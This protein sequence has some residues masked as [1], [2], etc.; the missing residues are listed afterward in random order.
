M[1]SKAFLLLILFIIASFFD[2][3]VEATPSFGDPRYEAH[4][5]DT[6][7]AVIV[8]IASIVLV[9]IS[10]WA[11]S[12]KDKASPILSYAPLVGVILLA[13]VRLSSTVASQITP[14]LVITGALFA[15][16][17]VRMERM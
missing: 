9:I 8:F 13:V 17:A 3:I 10:K 12:R 5:M 14:V 15:L 16:L 4:R 6:V 2:G 11:S 7:L 1:K